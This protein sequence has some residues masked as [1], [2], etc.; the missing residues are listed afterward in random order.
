[1]FT[2]SPAKRKAGQRRS[3]LVHHC[4]SSKADHRVTNSSMFDICNFMAHQVHIFLHF[5]RP[6]RVYLC[7][8]LQT[9]CQFCSWVIGQSIFLVRMTWR[10]V[11]NN[12][13]FKPFEGLK[14]RWY[15]SSDSFFFQYCG[16]HQSVKSCQNQ[17]RWLKQ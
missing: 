2:F 9:E 12:G 4:S 13:M 11:I 6:S 14:L 5:R 7:I 8:A 3:K 17:R 10:W 1:M 15:R 16:V